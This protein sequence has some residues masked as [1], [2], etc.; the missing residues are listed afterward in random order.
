MRYENNPILREYLD[1]G[2]AG[3]FREHLKHPGFELDGSAFAATLSEVRAQHPH[4]GDDEA[5]A[6]AVFRLLTS[7]A[8][9]EIAVALPSRWYRVRGWI[10]R[11]SPRVWP[12]IKVLWAIAVLVLC[13]LILCTEAAH[14][15]PNPDELHAIRN[16]MS[17]WPALAQGQPN[18]L[19]VQFQNGG[20]VLAT[21]PAGLVAINCSTNMSCSFSGTTFTLTASSSSSTQWSAITAATNANTGAFLASGNTW[22]F[23]GAT[24]F[25]LRAGAGA[26][27]SANGDLA[28]DSTS[29]YWRIW[30]GAANRYNIASTNL[31]ASGQAALSNGDGSYTFADPIVSGPDAVGA[32]PT[33]NPVQTGCLFLTTPATL[34][35]NQ[36]G[37]LQCDNG[38]NLLV[39]VSNSVTVSGTVTA[40]Q[41]GTWTVQPGNTANTTPWLVTPNDG[42]GHSTPAGDASA[43]SIHETVD[44]A[45]LAATQSGNWTSRVVGNAGGAMDAAGQN[46]ASPANEL[47][48]GCQFNTSPTTITSTN[49]SPNQCDNKGS[50]NV[51]IQTIAGTAPTTA[52]KLDVKGADGDVFVRQTTAA[53]LNVRT[54]TSGATGAAPPAHG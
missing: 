34:A 7:G 31:G 26:T 16:A 2:A 22:D 9:P 8:P 41:G 36:V 11:T 14:A 1:R 24:L 15:E 44:N 30:Q 53:N 20:S 38:Q 51:D 27:T 18:G 4:L 46:A 50:Q 23:T 45:T 52:G 54:D 47:L 25:K 13:L 42:A 40:N 5:E 35:N 3:A 21:R 39:K 10:W 37:E 48:V 17:G 33:R 29:S 28:Y 6:R 43:R 12:W 32:A 19:I 49:M